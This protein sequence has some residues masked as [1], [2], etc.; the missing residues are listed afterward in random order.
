MLQFQRA[1]C[2]KIFELNL[3]N[4]AIIVFVKINNF[5]KSIKRCKT[6]D[7][8]GMNYY[9]RSS[10]RLKGTKNEKPFKRLK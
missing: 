10:L 4:K 8:Q 1:D 9:I 3:G 6:I 5:F 2:S 7:F